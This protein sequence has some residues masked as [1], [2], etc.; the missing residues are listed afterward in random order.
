MCDSEFITLFVIFT[1]QI[2]I[3]TD[4]VDLCGVYI[5]TETIVS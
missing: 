3:I 1:T 2:Y 4:L 5:I